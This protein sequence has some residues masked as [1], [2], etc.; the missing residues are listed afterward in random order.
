M[1]KIILFSDGTG[2]TGGGVNSN[3]WRL[4]EAIDVNIKDQV[5]FYDDGVGTQENKYIRAV[6]SGTGFGVRGNV[7]DLYSFLL[8]QY[9]PGDQIYLFGFSRGAFTARVLSNLLFYCGI[10]NAKD[11]DG[12]RKSPQQIADL[13]ERAMKAYEARAFCDPKKGKPAQFRQEYGWR[14]P[15]NFQGEPGWF[16]LHFVGVWDTVEAYGLPVDE[17]TN[18]L[19]SLGFLK[20]RFKE[21]GRLRENDLHP[22]LINGFHAIATD[23][24]R[25]SFHPILWVENAPFDP[26]SGEKLPGWEQVMAIGE[27]PNRNIHQVWFAGMHSNVG[28]G[29]PQDQMAYASLLWMLEKAKGCGLVFDPTLVDLYKQLA[30]S[31]G[32]MYDS[33]SGAAIYF[34]YRPRDLRVLCAT[35]GLKEPT[36]HI[37]LFDRLKRHTQDYAPTGIPA[38]YRI[39][40][41]HLTSGE[42]NPEGRLAWQHRVD[43]LIWMRRVLYFV[44]VGCTLSV[45]GILWWFGNHQTPLE[46]ALNCGPTKFFYHLFQPIVQTAAALIPEYFKEGWLELGRRPWTLLAFGVALVACNRLSAWLKNKINL[47]SNAAWTVGFHPKPTPLTTNAEKQQMAAQAKLPP[48]PQWTGLKKFRERFSAFAD[49]F[50]RRVVPILFI[51]AL[52]AGMAVIACRWF[53]PMFMDCKSSSS[54]KEHPTTVQELAAKFEFDT[55]NPL[56]PTPVAVEA[57]KHYRVEVDAHPESEAKDPKAPWFDRNSPASPEGVFKPDSWV[58]QY[59]NFAKRA[60]QE[61]WFKVI[62]AVGL[63]NQELI[64]IGAG[65]DITPKNSGRLFLFVNDVPLFYDNNRG[66]ATVTVTQVE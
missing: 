46:T 51:F 7:K 5:T 65:C 29:Y 55:K 1:K 16:T 41:P 31:D 24:E 26:D 32:R 61:P 38:A 62:A 58:F 36:L 56:F 54:M 33:R 50:Q 6:S 47:H 27:N 53:G 34:R 48:P 37:S 52:L 49:G 13:S 30:D 39:E 14:N 2:N 9:E 44:F 17:M 66:R 19:S 40:P 23:D 28:G 3:V 11:A 42:L 63:E 10:A 35:A 4:Y 21:K 22:L 45:L 59:G 60:P 20:L 25:H 57:G 8:Q 18:A 12:D 15:L 43:D 64:P